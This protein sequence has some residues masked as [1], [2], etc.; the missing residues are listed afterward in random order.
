MTD[1]ALSEP[2][3]LS[4]PIVR[5]EKQTITE[6]RLREPMSG[7]L[8]GLK[9]FDLIQLDVG[10]L[11]EIL[12]RLTQPLLTKDEVK[13]LGLSDLLKTGAALLTFFGDETSADSPAA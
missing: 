9:L 1:R 6:I 12:P 13:G 8:R 7:E 10:T 5:G 11:H 3:T 4:R 2:V